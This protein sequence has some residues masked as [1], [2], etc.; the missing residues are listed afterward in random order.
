VASSKEL[1][2]VRQLV[3]ESSVEE[4]NQLAEEYFASLTSWDYHLA[5]PFGS[6]DDTPQLL[7]NFAVVM[8]GLSLCPGL[9]VLEFGAG[10]CWA[11]RF[12]NQLG[13]EVFAVDV[14]LTALR[15]GAELYRRQPLI[16]NKPEPRFLHFDG[17]R[18]DL[19]D[20][21]VDRIICLDAFHHTPNPAQV[22]A[23][24]CRVLK[25][26]GIAGFAEPG[27]EHSK[28]PLSQYEMRTFKVIEND[29]NIRAIWHDA[30]LA[31]FTDI[32]LAVFNV[33]PVHMELRE[34]E[35]F[36]AGGKT[37]RDY[38]K[39]TRGFLQNQRNFFLYK[40][41][42]PRSDS[43]LRAGLTAQIKIS[44]STL[45][46]KEGKPIIAQARVKNDGA[47]IWLP[48]SAGLGAVHLGVHVYDSAGEIVRQSFHWEALTPG[49]G[50]PVLPDEEVGVEVNAPPLPKGK[51]ILE[52]DMVSN[53]V[54]WFALNG[55]QQVKVPLEVS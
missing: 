48:R 28:S 6:L 44:P 42:P 46:A 3:A 7:I 23:E 20:Q 12:L 10:T 2:D 39:T 16:G 52:F 31:G 55:S 54:C 37:T 32:K 17:V 26:G 34:F 27:P 15:I 47:S 50:R 8:Q 1:I 49:E 53:D 41:K 40:G 25:D 18:L 43:R 24:M 22:L 11:S 45:T 4:L 35:D 51:Y 9:S 5:K 29:I 38:V 19:P 33:P 13:C 30:K 36:L 21:S 14:S